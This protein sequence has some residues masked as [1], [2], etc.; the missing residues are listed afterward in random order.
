VPLTPE[1]IAC[2]AGATWPEGVVP[3]AGWAGEI[4]VPTGGL[5]VLSIGAGALLGY[6]AGGKH[7]SWTALGAVVGWYLHPLE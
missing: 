2:P 7:M 3:P 5:P 4:G 1:G 6:F